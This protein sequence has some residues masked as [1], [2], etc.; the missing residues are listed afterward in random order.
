MYHIS[1]N[2]NLSR[3]ITTL[4]RNDLVRVIFLSLLVKSQST[5]SLT[6]SILMALFFVVIMNR[7]VTEETD[8]V[9]ETFKSIKK[10]S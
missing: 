2:S 4:F 5:Q 9:K 10:I 3:S 6:V 8:G 1:K 7:I